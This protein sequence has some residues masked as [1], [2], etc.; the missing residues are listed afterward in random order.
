[1]KFS[2]TICALF[3]F[4]NSFSQGSS[5]DFL[6]MYLDVTQKKEAKYER[7]LK[8]V[9]E[10]LYEA[11]IKL[12]SGTLKATGVYVDIDG[13]L[14]PH[15]YFTFYYANGQVE[16]EGKYKKGYKVDTWKRYMMDGTERSPKYYKSD[17]GNVLSGLR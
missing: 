10:D 16:S 7:Y 2:L 9:D 15:G 6:D 3:V 13:E 5:S 14:I 17:L 1:M 12:L 4:F 11:E 8:Q